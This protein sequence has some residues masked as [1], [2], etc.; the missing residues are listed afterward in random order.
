MRK[1]NNKGFTLAELLIVVAI[2]AVLVAISIPVFTG[3]LDKA[4]LAAATANARGAVAEY[5]ADCLTADPPIVVDDDGVDAAVQS[6]ELGECSASA[7][8]GVVTVT[9]PKNHTMTFTYDTGDIGG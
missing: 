8:G 6:A 5:V 4:K 9:S 3:Q 1:N 2:I 7:A